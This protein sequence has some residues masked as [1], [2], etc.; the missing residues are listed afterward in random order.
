MS[1]SVDVKPE[2][3]PNPINLKSQG[4]IPVG[5]LGGAEFSVANVDLST[6]QFHPMDRCEQAVAPKKSAFTDINHDGYTDIIFHFATQEVRFQPGDSSACL[7]GT[8]LDTGRH[9]CGHDTVMI[10]GE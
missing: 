4:L 9:F 6:V 3:Y 5:L 8:L 2:S 1:V 10:K 7:H